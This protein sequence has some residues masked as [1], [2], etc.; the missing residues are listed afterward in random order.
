LPVVLVMP[1]T[2]WPTVLPAAPRVLPMPDAA[3]PK[4]PV[5]T[6]N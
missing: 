2:P 5:S 4:K 1:E 3:V 6:V